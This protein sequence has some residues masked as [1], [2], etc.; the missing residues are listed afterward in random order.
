MRD[1]AYRGRRSLLGV[2]ECVP[3]VSEGRDRRGD[4]RVRRGVRH[5]VARRAPRPRSPPLGVHAR[6]SRRRRRGDRGAR[7]RARRS[8][9]RVDLDRHEGVHPRLGALDVV[10]FVA[11]GDTASV[12]AVDAA[13]AF[14][15]WAVDDPRRAGVLLRPR[16]R[17]AAHAAVDA[18]RRAFRTRAPDLVPGALRPGVGAIAVGARPVLVAVNCELD[19]D[20]RALARRDRVRRARA[21][22]RRAA[23]RARARLPPRVTRPACR[24]R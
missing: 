16:R 21:R 20:D 10:P 4:R 13:H 24:C 3:N 19:R 9:A 18:R 8:A 11:L 14:G 1:G 6:G 15:A 17:A 22:G 12:D 23:R 5:V 7:A 2:L